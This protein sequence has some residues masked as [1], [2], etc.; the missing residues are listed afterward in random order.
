MKR[1]ATLLLAAGMLLGTVAG[2]RA[3]DFKIG[4]EWYM[5][6]GAGQPNPVSNARAPGDVKRKADSEDIFRANQMVR[7]KLEAS[8]SENLSGTVYFEIGDMTWGQDQGETNGGAMGADRTNVIKL[9]NAHLDWA[10][11]NT[12]L[13]F[14]MGLQDVTLPNAAGGPAVFATDA[15][16][17]TTSYQFNDNVGLTALWARPFNDNYSDPAAWNNDNPGRVNHLDN[18]DFFALLLPLKFDA[19]EATPW[20]M[21]GLRGKNTGKFDAWQDG[22]LGDGWPQYTFGP[23]P[24][25]I[26]GDDIGGRPGDHTGKTSKAY[27][28]MFWAGLPLT[29]T[30]LEPLNIEFDVNYGYV[31]GMGRYDVYKYG[32]RTDR[33]G[34]TRR[35]GWLA[36]ALVEYK[37]D[38]GIPG[39]FGWYAS[40][41]DGDPKNGS[42]RMPSIAAYGNFTSFI[43]DGNLGWAPHW[44]WLDYGA[45]YAGTWG[46]GA[47]VKDVRF[48]E[49]LGHTLTVAW[50]G[51]TNSPSMTK[52]MGT[53]YAWNDSR[54]METFLTTSDGLLE[55]NL[56][57]SWQVYENLEMNLELGYVV[58]CMDNGTWK[59]AGGENSTSFEK[60]D[61]WKAQLVLAYT[62]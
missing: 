28:S 19:F 55:F 54:F 29:L 20:A 7:L 61:T 60:K 59:K 33:R 8:A 35:E 38:W 22:A 14:R 44:T 46:I 10:V 25:V 62:F 9:K 15:A 12:A 41:E 1:I 6:F 49:N 26:A 37:A 11:P 57:N 56:V 52:Y 45:S 3:V 58:N 50:W 17:V 18:M 48:L 2:A 24:S 34:D 43:G 30:A 23:Y 31:E 32:Q 5:G 47:R 27:G 40:G 53:S 36:K 4:G 13:K 51:G 21:Y 16:G 39:I 42:E